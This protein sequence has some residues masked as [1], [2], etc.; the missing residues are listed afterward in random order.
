ME[1]L[2]RLQGLGRQVRGTDG[3]AAA[4]L[5]VGV[6]FGVRDI[7]SNMLSG[8]LLLIERPVRSGDV[9]QVG[10]H[11]GEVTHI[12]L[13]SLTLRSWDNIDVN[14]PNNET[15]V[16]SFK[17]WTYEDSVIRTV[18]TLKTDF[19]EDPQRIQKLIM[20]T[21][22]SHKE[23]L[24]DPE[25]SVLLVNIAD[26]ILEFEVRYYIDL[27]KTLSRAI[28]KSEVLI[29]TWRA[30]HAVGIQ[31]AYPHHTVAIEAPDLNSRTPSSRIQPEFSMESR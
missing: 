13:R 11:E 30:L 18:F 25:A 10:E 23:I 7:V 22:K 6:A 24:L 5:G 15:T 3:V 20:E 14:I 28:M 12:G 17:N 9:V 16:K 21:L 29:S 2:H 31:V 19:S 8:L 1:H 26:S 4:A 27:R